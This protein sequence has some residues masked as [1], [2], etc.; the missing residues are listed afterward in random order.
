MRVD[1]F[2]N[3]LASDSQ[4][5]YYEGYYTPSGEII[6]SVYFCDK[7]GEF[8]IS[9]IGYDLINNQYFVKDPNWFKASNG[10]ESHLRTSEYIEIKGELVNIAKLKYWRTST[11]VTGNGISSF[12]QEVESII[13][14]QAPYKPLITIIVN[15]FC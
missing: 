1:L 10:I 14:P 8:L 4:Y 13:V 7:K 12:I 9:I 6:S 2:G 3:K 15:F 11:K 5:E